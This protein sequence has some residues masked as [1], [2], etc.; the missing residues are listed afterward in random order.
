MA[1]LAADQAVRVLSDRA[2]TLGRYAT[3]NPAAT[4]S[5]TP[6]THTQI[7]CPIL[8]DGDQRPARTTLSDVDSPDVTVAWD[9]HHRGAVGSK[10][11][12]VR[13]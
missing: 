3:A 1:A 4:I 5:T 13:R 2:R 12:W 9:G 8:P 10:P 11:G 7:T 6:T